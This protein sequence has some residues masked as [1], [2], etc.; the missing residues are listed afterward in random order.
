VCQPLEKI[1]DA[2]KLYAILADKIQPY[3]ELIKK[4]RSFNKMIKELFP[5][6]YSSLRL[7]AHH[8]IER[9]SYE[10]F[11]DIFRRLGWS[12]ASEMASLAVHYEA[13]I[14]SPK[15][16]LE[17]P[18]TAFS[19]TRELINIIDSKEYQTFE[20]M[21]KAYEDYYKSSG[22]AKKVEGFFAD[23]RRRYGELV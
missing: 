17:F 16:L 10:K 20:E 3:N 13:H 12:S 19:L 2:E 23:V 6:D 22:W 1:R 9:R 11:E 5:E 7:D 4:T 18:T 15:K 14:L 8:I 21:L